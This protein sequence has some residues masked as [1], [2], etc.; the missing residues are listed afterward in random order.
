MITK[1][2][3]DENIQD[4]SYVVEPGETLTLR[5]ASF[6]DFPTAKIHVQVKKEGVFDG[7]FADFSQGKGR[8]SLTV[9]LLEE[10]AKAT[11]HYAGRSS[12]ESDKIVDASIEHLSKATEADVSIWNHHGSEPS[13][14]HRNQPYP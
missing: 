10:G 2:L 5:L 3:I 12:G 4:L 13:D 9:E 8:F 6:R 7:A 11:W 1:T 14:L